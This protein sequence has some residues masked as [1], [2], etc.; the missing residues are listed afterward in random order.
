MNDPS[1]LSESQAPSDLKFRSPLL[2]NRA[3]SALLV[4]DVQTKLVSAIAGHDRVVD[5]IG[6]LIEG[7]NLLGIPIRV[8]EQYPHGLG[9]TVESLTSRL[10]AGTATSEMST[11]P[12]VRVVH[13]KRMF[14][15]RECGSL[16][17]E[18][19]AAGVRN[20]LLCGIETHVC[21]AQTALDC[22]AAGF[23]VYLAVDAVGSRFAVDH[24]TAL[25]RLEA[26]GV[27][28]TSAE[29]ALFEWCETSSA[30]EFKL[31]SQLV[32]RPRV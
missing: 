17:D 32:Q 25:R 19:A 13:E 3:D 5:G 27:I 16:F 4:I 20:L 21:V 6:R 11:P 9:S 10:E 18:L 23:N 2:M 29:A 31:I 1:K 30:D 14:S 8:T 24:E 15:C 22:T 7:A 28:P 12:T 26:S